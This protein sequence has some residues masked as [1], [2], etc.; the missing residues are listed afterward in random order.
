MTVE[1]PQTLGTGMWV[2]VRGLVPGEETVLRFLPGS[3]TNYRRR[4]LPA[5]SLLGNTLI[6]A[7]AGDRVRLPAFDDLTEDDWIELEVL[8]IGYD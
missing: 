5:D 4:E 7:K 8:A 2:K 6:G 3:K 1:T